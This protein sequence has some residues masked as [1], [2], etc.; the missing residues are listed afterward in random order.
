M[1][2]TFGKN[3]KLKSKKA[4]ENLFSEGQSYV[5]HPIRIVYKVNPKQDYTI[6]VGESVAKKKFKHA[7][8]RNLLKRRIKEAYRLNKQ[9][10]QLPEDVSVDILFIYTSS[11][12]KDYSTIE[13]SIKEILTKLDLKLNKKEQQ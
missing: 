3:E 13:H 9:L 2:L 4:I 11:K 1:K 5:S 7:V 12:I 8:D 6:R 10:V